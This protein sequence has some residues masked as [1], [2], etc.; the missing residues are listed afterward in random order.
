MQAGRQSVNQS[1]KTL[2]KTTVWG[3]GICYSVFL[4]AVQTFFVTNGRAIPPFG[5]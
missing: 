4:A 2:L 1:F 3:Y 5:K